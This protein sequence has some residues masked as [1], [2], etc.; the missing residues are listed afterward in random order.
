MQVKEVKVKEMLFAVTAG[1]FYCDR[2]QGCRGKGS[3]LN[4]Q[5]S[6]AHF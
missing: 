5:Q 2:A 3:F 6:S 1:S 4:P